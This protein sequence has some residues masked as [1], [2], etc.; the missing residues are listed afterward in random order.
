[1]H[2]LEWVTL[3]GLTGVGATAVELLAQG[4]REAGVALENYLTER[5]ALGSNPTIV[6]RPRDCRIRRIHISCAARS[7]RWARRA[8]DQSGRA[9]TESFWN[10]YR[11]RA[12]V[13]TQSLSRLGLEL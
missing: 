13:M 5:R 11:A 3:Q 8:A 1:M 2:S 10:R 6:G 9:C 7:P 12:R 4:A